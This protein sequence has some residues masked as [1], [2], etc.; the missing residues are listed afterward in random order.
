MTA[1]PDV[2]AGAKFASRNN[3][4]E[5]LDTGVK[6]VDSSTI[7]VPA[8]AKAK[9]PTGSASEGF[10]TVTSSGFDSY[11]STAASSVSCAGFAKS[12]GEQGVQGARAVTG[13]QATDALAAEA[14][15]AT[16]GA[17]PSVADAIEAANFGS[18]IGL[19]VNSFDESGVPG[20]G[21]GSGAVTPSGFDSKATATPPVDPSIKCQ[22]VRKPGFQPASKAP[23]PMH[24][25]T[26]ATTKC[27]TVTPSGTDS[28]ASSTV[29]S[30][31]NRAGSA[32]S[33]GGQVAGRACKL[34][35]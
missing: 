29:D 4:G 21:N 12:V 20:R 9:P 2:P 10:T 24:I 32:C 23:L 30:T 5:D 1:T 34:Q 6:P 26:P 17:F 11:V 31:A 22:T 28:N 35:L 14:L 25:Q 8:K 18:G 7:E 27:P 3:P 16:D 33:G 19:A 15:D 13:A